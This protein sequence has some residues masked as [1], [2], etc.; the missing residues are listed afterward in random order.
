MVKH[1]PVDPSE[2]RNGIITKLSGLIPLFAHYSHSDGST[3]YHVNII[4]SI[5]DGA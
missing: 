1:Q 2:V 4:S 3:L 5:A